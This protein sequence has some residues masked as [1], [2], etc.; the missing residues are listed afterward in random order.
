[1]SGPD[2]ETVQ[3]AQV[4]EPREALEGLAPEVARFCRNL[5]GNAAEAADAAQEALLA[6]FEGIAG[7]RGEAS[8]KTW[9]MRIAHKRCIDR[10]RRTLRR[11]TDLAPDLDG[12]V[13]GAAALDDALE[14]A[15]AGEVL[16]SML[17]TLPEIDRSILLLRFDHDL[18]FEEIGLALG[19]RGD[20]AKVRAHRALVRLRPRLEALGVKP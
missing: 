12:H 3:A 11:R 19:I 5:L 6:A 18:G 14:G 16:R 9:V 4:R 7:F 10:L 17:A 13:S 8:L 15:Q 20:N 2:R 1:M